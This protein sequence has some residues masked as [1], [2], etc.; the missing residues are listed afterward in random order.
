MPYS[1]GDLDI[2]PL[3]P[4]DQDLL[5]HSEVHLPQGEKIR[6]GKVI[7]RSCDENGAIT[8]SYNENP[9][10]NTLVYDVEFPVGE[11]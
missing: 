5:I 9:I 2:P 8:G 1:D 11:V 10:L 6:A 3:T 7:R 4:E